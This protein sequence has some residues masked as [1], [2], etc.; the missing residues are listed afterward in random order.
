MGRSFRSV[1]HD[2]HISSLMQVQ[3]HTVMH[4]LLPFSRD[5][6]S[7]STFYSVD[8]KHRC[9]TVVMSSL[10]EAFQYEGIHF[11]YHESSRPS[12]KLMSSH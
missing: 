1:L 8:K 6:T 4:K 10:D 5:V 12:Q 3:L 7:Y 9:S 2:T 11:H